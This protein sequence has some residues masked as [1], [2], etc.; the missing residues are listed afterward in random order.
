MT[1]E[2]MRDEGERG[3]MEGK[4]EERMDGKKKRE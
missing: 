1:R 2:E 3:L 4:G